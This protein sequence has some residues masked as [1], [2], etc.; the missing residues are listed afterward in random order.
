M[1]GSDMRKFKEPVRGG[2]TAV[3]FPRGCAALVEGSSE[4]GMRL[5]NGSVT[6][7]G[8]VEGGESIAQATMTSAPG[9]DRL[10]HNSENPV[11]LF[12]PLQC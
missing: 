10:M 3:A 6:G 5:R 8:H 12:R 9:M 1:S 7:T 4:V 11:V 2:K